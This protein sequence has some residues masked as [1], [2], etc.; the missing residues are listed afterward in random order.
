M[1]SM[2]VASTCAVASAA[3]SAEAAVTWA[4]FGST[5]LAY[6]TVSLLLLLILLLL[7]GAAPELPAAAT[8]AGQ[9]V[10][11]SST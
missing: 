4:S 2:H 6:L 11:A 7:L 3:G 1:A 10:T 9:H 8:L 5:S